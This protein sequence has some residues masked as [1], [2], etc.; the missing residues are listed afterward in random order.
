MARPML[1]WVF[2]SCLV[3]S[4]GLGS[5]Q[6]QT[7]KKI[8]TVDSIS[9]VPGLHAHP[10]I[11]MPTTRPGSREALSKKGLSRNARHA[12]SNRAASNESSEGGSLRFPADLQY[13]GGPVVRYAQ[14]HSVFLNSTKACPPNSCFGD[15]IGFLDDL[16]RSQFIHLTDQYVHAHASHRYTNGTNYAVPGYTPSAGAGKP[17]TNE[18]MAVVAYALAAASGDFGLNHVY[19]LFLP[20]GQDVC[21][22]STFSVCY[23]PD[24]QDTWH[25]CAYH[26][27]A[28]D[29]NGNI[30]LFTVIPFVNA[31]GCN[32]RPGTPN[33][34]KADST[35]NTLSHELIETV[36]DPFGD[37]WW[38]QVNLLLFGE[39]IADECIFEYFTETEAFSDPSL[40]RLN[41]KLYA[42]QPEYSNR[43]HACSTGLGDDD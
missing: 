39:E 19:H 1:K 24:N 26:S 35:N 25:F 3:L 10:P 27:A 17:F 40:V 34:Q 41:H 22:D 36:T 13:D 37:A 18:D 11:A 2:P 14:N 12:S 15:P 6:A 31:P 7:Q 38:N 33:G 42:I 16:G 30:A 28:E 29:A 23:S 4:L 8:V 32:V 43:Q 9:P 21:F 20:P 5:L